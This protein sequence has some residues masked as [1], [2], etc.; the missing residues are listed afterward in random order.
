M[1]WLRSSRTPPSPAWVGLIATGVVMG[2]LA[3]WWLLAGGPSARRKHVPTASAPGAGA[4]SAERPLPE[5]LGPI[6]AFDRSVAER[7]LRARPRTTPLRG[8]L[9]LR[10]SG[11]A[12]D[13]PRGRPFVRADQAT[14]RLAL[15]G[16][17]SGTTVLTG[18]DAV[19]PRVWLYRTAG[20][21]VWNWE[22][23]LAA[24]LGNAPPGTAAEGAG[25]PRTFEVQGL[26]VRDGFVSVR[27]PEYETHF[28]SVDALL[29]RVALA[30]PRLPVPRVDVARASAVME[31]PDL[32]W[33][34][35]LTGRDA[36]VTLPAN[37]THYTVAELAFGHTRLTDIVG[38]YDA[39]LP[40]LG[41]RATGNA[42]AF[43]AADLKTFAPK[44]DLNGVGS[45]A[46]SVEPTPDN[47]VRLALTNAHLASDGSAVNGSVTVTALGDKEKP[48][49]V[50]ADLRLEPLA[51]SLVE[52]LTGRKL[53][54]RGEVTGTVR[55]R[56]G[57]IR[58]DLTGHLTTAGVSP[59]NVGIT[60][61]AAFS[62]DGIALRE[63][64]AD[65]KAVP[66]AALRPLAPAIPLRGSITGRIALSGPVNG[67]PMRL[68]VR[69]DL[70]VGVALVNGS[71]T[72]PAGAGGTASYEVAGRLLGVRLRDVIDA[73]VPPATLTA[74]FTARGSG[75]DP[76]TASAAFAANGRFSG[77][78][79]DANDAL[80]L[81]GS[82]AGGVLRLDT[83]TAGLAS[84]TL[85]AAGSWP[86]HAGAGGGIGYRLELADLAPFAPYLPIGGGGPAAGSLVLSGT[87]AGTL[88]L[89]HLNGR[90]S[91]SGVRAGTWAVGSAA[92]T[93]DV[94][95]G[96]PV[97]RIGLEL[98]ARELR[99]PG[100]G[101]FAT[102]VAS[103]RLA[104]PLLDLN[105]RGERPGG[106]LIELVAN[107]SVPANGPR[108]VT[109]QR[110]VADIGEHRWQ[111]GGPAVLR[112]QPGGRA[113][114]ENLLVQQTDGPGRLALNGTLLPADASD[115][116][117]EATAV[118]VAAF[119]QAAGQTAP[120][121]GLLSASAA[122]HGPAATP[123]VD[124]TFRLD[125]GSVAGIAVNLLQGT[126]V[127]R[128]GRLTADTRAV[129]AQGGAI[130]ANA[131]LPVALRLGLPPRGSLLPTGPV[132]GSL[133][134][135][136]VPLAFLSSL[137]TQVTNVGGV[138]SAR[139]SLGGTSQQPV[140][141]G[142]AVLA[143][144]A[145][146]VPAAAQR[147]TDIAGSVTLRDRR[148]VVDSLRLR[149][150]GFATLR[151]SIDFPELRNPVADLTM[152]FDRFR[153]L[154]NAD[155]PDAAA[156]GQLSLTGPLLTPTIHGSLRLDD[157]NLM[158]P[159][160]DGTGDLMAEAAALGVSD[161]GPEPGQQAVPAVPLSQR[162][163]LVG[164][165]LTA[166]PN[167]W[168][169]MP[170][171]RAQLSG[172]LTLQKEPDSELRI[173]GTLRGQRGS[174]T[175]FAGPIV[176]RL[177]I[178]SASIRF[179]GTADLN[180]EIDAVATKTILTP[181]SQPVEIQA[182]VTGTLQNPQLTLSTAEGVQVPE[183]ELLSFLVFGQPSFALGDT[184]FGQALLQQT[185]YGGLAEVASLQLQQSALAYGL[186]L[187]VF[188]IQASSATGRPQNLVLGGELAP[189]VFLTVQTAIGVLFGD[190]GQGSGRPVAVR[191]EWQVSPRLTATLGW[192][193]LSPIR[194]LHG[195][196][197]T[198]PQQL[199]RD[200]QYTVELRRRW[201]Y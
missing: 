110:L 175:V 10:L 147:Y 193:P 54:Y 122:V 126:L 161:L 178:S 182:H 128:A 90:L 105:V 156:W 73:N 177:D 155:N 60:G 16:L 139:M 15:A 168:F 32:G 184:R 55:G 165:Q 163:R 164:V 148:V 69:L 77:W 143:G 199:T 195:F 129:L 34:L 81:R 197:T 18:V 101:S 127:Y 83:L 120:V 8:A 53:P 6:T 79:T 72:L 137:T 12:W 132:V 68:N 94:Q 62:P 17:L 200:N 89:P 26:S 179:L 27:V 86:F 64:I 117:F 5:V 190:V 11:V 95:L 123:V 201:T 187:Q 112:W 1:R 121:S 19:R 154:G 167:L 51:L 36:V 113:V 96:G 196:F 66:L 144:G 150:D 30:G 115:Y 104:S 192:E 76:A 7:L 118:P 87:A 31:R 136:A 169:E 185:V 160:A 109:L 3:L 44:R 50:S 119:Y 116:R 91:A 42:P 135:N 170:G 43:D 24:F 88:Q 46:W 188:E 84:A 133:V 130:T 103:A 41:V 151:G 183:S 99:A 9:Q 20:D 171:T 181:Q 176:R 166:G 52:R 180:P 92:G 78:R 102:I 131:A 93:Y 75:F 28:L 63:A 108:S 59:F 85:A 58:F 162:V 153:P 98:Q 70:P 106:G 159:A 124:G 57:A 39:R 14:G 141:A 145:V 157:G 13:D 48:G 29:S 189:D 107:G 125:S 134:A 74:E 45:F 33:R 25:G 97:P 22:R 65:L 158:V 111:L 172:T 114:V 38:I 149:S 71:V 61:T 37:E 56:E 67:S 174:Y 2:L 82:I 49:L 146:T 142:A 173:V 186:P 138:F 194:N 191:L 21:P 140:L 47:G 23:A 35:A 100:A 80:V 40:G 198:V 152:T 4:R